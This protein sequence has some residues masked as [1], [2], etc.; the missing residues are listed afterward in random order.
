M[1]SKFDDIYHTSAP[2]ETNF[3]NKDVESKIFMLLILS[4]LIKCASTSKCHSSV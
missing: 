3:E 1:T 2:G 4:I